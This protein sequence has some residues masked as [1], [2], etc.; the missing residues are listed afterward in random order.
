MDRKTFLRNSLMGGTAI[1]LVPDLEHWSADE[2]ASLR[3]LLRT[4][5]GT[6]EEAY[7]ALLRGSPRLWK[8]WSVVVRASA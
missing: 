8:A 1:D 6:T 3:D 2:K 7:I 4:K 5:G